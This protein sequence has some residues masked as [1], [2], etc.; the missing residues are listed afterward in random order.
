ML[1]RLYVMYAAQV[2]LL[3]GTIGWLAGI[4][5]FILPGWFVDRWYASGRRDAH[6]RYFV[7]ATLLAAGFA[8]VAFKLASSLWVFLPAF[9]ALHFLH[10]FTGPA[11]AHL[12]LATPNPDRKSTRLNS[13]P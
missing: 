5:G 7:Y 12:Q 4:A 1:M 8:M 6:L 9:A 13:S 3:V 10:P 11:V 2:G